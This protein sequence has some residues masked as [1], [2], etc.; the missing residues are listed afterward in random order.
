MD[1]AAFG[2][3]VGRGRPDAGTELQEDRQF[4]VVFFDDARRDRVGRQLE[5]V[6]VVVLD[7]V[8]GNGLDLVLVFVGDLDVL[9]LRLLPCD[10]AAVEVRLEA[11]R[12]AVRLG[13]LFEVQHAADDDLI[14]RF[15]LFDHVVL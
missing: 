7:A 3:A 5:D 2:G 4:R 8:G 12:L 10:H 9:K 14:A 13:L 1:V 6:A 11:G 15:G